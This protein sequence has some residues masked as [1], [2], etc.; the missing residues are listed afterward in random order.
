M[1]GYCVTYQI[2]FMKNEGAVAYISCRVL[3]FTF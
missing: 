2:I 1:K 3:V